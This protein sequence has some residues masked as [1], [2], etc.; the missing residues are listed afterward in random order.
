MGLCHR[1]AVQR[2]VQLTVPGSTE[3]V[4]RFVRRLDGHRG[5]AIVAG[6]GILGPEPV[7]AGCLA[8]DLAAV[9]GND[10]RELCG[11]N[12]RTIPLALLR[13]GKSSP[14]E[15]AVEAAKDRADSE[16]LAHLAR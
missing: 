6:V 10:R 16:A 3:P 8:E 4:P 15:G 1:H 12:C 7:D 13:P 2:R 9:I 11:V 5:G 14:R